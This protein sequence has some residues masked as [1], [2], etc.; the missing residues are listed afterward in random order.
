[1][2][3]KKN[4]SNKQQNQQVLHSVFIPIRIYFNVTSMRADTDPSCQHPSHSFKRDHFPTKML[5]CNNRYDVESLT[6]GPSLPAHRTNHI[7]QIPSPWRGENGLR[8][9][10]SASANQRASLHPPNS[11]E[12]LD[13]S[14]T[15]FQKTYLSL[16]TNRLRG[17]SLIS[18]G[19]LCLLT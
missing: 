13:Q 14:E 18:W 8:C 3:Q 1:M 4:N 7:P 19:V 15:A 16:S 17:W 10:S 5:G 6:G 9:T 12:R 11:L 2:T